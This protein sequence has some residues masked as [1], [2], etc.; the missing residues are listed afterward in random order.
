MSDFAAAARRLSGLYPRAEIARAAAAPAADRPLESY[1]DDPAGF[2]RDVLGVEYTADQTR[3]ARAL[4]GRVKINSGHSLGKTHLAASLC[5]WWHYTRDPGV[6]IT[7]AP[8]ERDVVDLLWTEIRLQHARARR[9]LPRRFPGPRDPAMFHHD[10]HWAKGYTARKGE[11]W[12]GRHLPNM[13]FV[14]DESEGI[15]PPYW[16]TTNTMYRPD[17]GDAWF[18]IGNPTT[19]SSQSYLEDIA[20][21]PGG[22]P[23]WKLFTLSALD[24][25]NVAAGLRGVP[26]PVPGAVTL[27]QVEQWVKD[28][29]TP[30]PR[31]EDRLPGD[32]EWPPGSG[33]FVRP[34]PT[35]KA[36]VLGVRPT[37]GVDTVWSLEAWESACRAKWDPRECWHREFGVSVGVD[38]SGYGDDDQCF[39]VRSGP[40]SLH[41]E[42]RNGWSPAKA[43]GRVKQ[44]CEQWAAWYNGL[45]HTPT[46]PPLAPQD[47]DVVFEFD[48]GFGL[49][50]HSHGGPEWPRWRGVTVGSRS[51][52][53][54][55]DGRPVYANTRAQLWFEAAAL[56][57]AGWVDLSRLDPETRDRLRVQLTTPYYEI[58]PDGSRLVEPKKDVKERLGRSPDDADALILSHAPAAG[59]APTVVTRPDPRE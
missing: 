26:P 11:S 47:V 12:Q 23:K 33:A 54:T 49:G 38:S 15:D 2:A 50:V 27:G 35:F 53:T 4:P 29:T 13:F 46:R 40:L 20:S 37:E 57:R 48:G 43:A 34:G 52:R 41:H 7:T 42:S 39:H 55:P 1:R 44:L 5:L 10:A 31:E 9:E 16:T 21:A 19:T 3:I 59:W 14:F 45:A 56:A 6:V 25:P 28:W 17:A 51:D 32:L 8:T 36:R 18:A 58:R 22:G 24:H 30:V